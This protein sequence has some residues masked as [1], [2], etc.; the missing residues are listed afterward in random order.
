[1]PTSPLIRYR[2]FNAYAA[3]MSSILVLFQR[4]KGYKDDETQL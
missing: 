2:C 3:I 1:M 4:G